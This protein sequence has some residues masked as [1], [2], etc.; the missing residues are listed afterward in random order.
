MKRIVICLDGT[1]N[2]VLDPDTVTNVVKLAQAVRPL[3][4]DNIEQIV[5]YNS[6][7]GTGDLLDKFLVVY[8]VAD[9]A[10]TSSVLMR[11]FL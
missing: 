1:W 11:F 8:S 5:Y 7:V 3:A 2:Q 9:C 6:G 4:S 10:T